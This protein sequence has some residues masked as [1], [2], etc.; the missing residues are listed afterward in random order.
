MEALDPVQLEDEQPAAQSRLP[1]TTIEFAGIFAPPLDIPLDF[2]GPT[3]YS[4][5]GGTVNVRAIAQNL[6][7]EKVLMDVAMADIIS[8]HPRWKSAVKMFLA[9]DASLRG[10]WMDQGGLAMMKMIEKW[11]KGETIT[12]DTPV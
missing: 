8:V 9:R 12:L 10:L 11:S 1:D 5:D 6:Y 2:Y 4:H 7:L 3:S